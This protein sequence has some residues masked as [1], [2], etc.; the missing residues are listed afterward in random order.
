MLLPK[1]LS[2]KFSPEKSLDFLSRKSVLRP[3]LEWTMQGHPS[4]EELGLPIAKDTSWL[5]DRSFWHLPPLFAPPYYRAPSAPPTL[6]H[7]LFHT[8][9]LLES[10]GIFG[11]KCKDDNSVSC[12]DLYHGTAPR[13]QRYLRRQSVNMRIDQT[14][15]F[16]C[17][18]VIL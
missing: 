9:M 4:R 2:R 14:A 5:V 12:A 18:L 15:H 16:F 7:K 1:F 8:A 10:I 11:V 13:L 17:V 3:A 6:V